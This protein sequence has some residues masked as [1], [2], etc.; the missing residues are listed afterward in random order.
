MMENGE[1]KTD[2]SQQY[3]I[4]SNLSRHQISQFEVKV[5]GKSIVTMKQCFQLN[6]TVNIGSQQLASKYTRYIKAGAT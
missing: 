2:T 4:V 1:A 5:S 3:D 6:F